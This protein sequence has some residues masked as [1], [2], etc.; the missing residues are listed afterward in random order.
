MALRIVNCVSTFTIDKTLS[1]ADYGNYNPKVF[2]GY[3]MKDK[4]ARILI[5]KSNKINVTGVKSLLEAKTV[6]LHNFPNIK[7]LKAKVVNLT[8]LALIK[9][10]INFNAVTNNSKYSWEPELFPGALFRESQSVA[11]FFP[12]GKVILTGFKNKTKLKTFYREFSR[13][14]PFKTV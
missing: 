1:P 7:I 8:A 4:R 12:S 10:P 2:S 9:K 11:I 13:N 5:Y 6:L 14:L 3:V